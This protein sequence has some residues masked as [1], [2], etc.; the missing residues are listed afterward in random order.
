M[1]QGQMLGYFAASAEVGIAAVVEEEIVAV[2][3]TAAEE[4]TVAVFVTVAEEET[5]AVVVTVGVEETLA[6][7][8]TVAEEKTAVVVEVGIVVVLEE[9]TVA[10][11]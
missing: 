9:E 2:A 8:L 4:E 1:L 5:A 10:A 11:A 7:A 3:V 6:A